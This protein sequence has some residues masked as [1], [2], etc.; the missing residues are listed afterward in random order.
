MSNWVSKG[1]LAGAKRHDSKHDTGLSMNA[2]IAQTK[3]TCYQNLTG[4]NKRPLHTG[5]REGSINVINKPKSCTRKAN[6][7]HKHMTD[8]GRIAQDMPACEITKADYKGG[9]KRRK[10]NTARLAPTH[11]RY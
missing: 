3:S 1:G 4:T 9:R 6:I 2:V 10:R 7:F 5:N 11:A 8:I